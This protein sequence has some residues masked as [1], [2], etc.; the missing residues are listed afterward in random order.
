M[1]ICDRI[2]FIIQYYMQPHKENDYKIANL[3]LRLINAA[4]DT[5]IISTVAVLIMAAD[6][7]NKY[8]EIN[9]FNEGVHS[10]VILY[11]T[12]QFFYYIT[13]ESI[14]GKT[15]GKFISNTAIVNQDT[16]KRT[17]IINILGWTF[18]RFIPGY[19]IPVIFTK[20]KSGLHDI[21]GK[22]LV[23]EEKP[24]GIIV[25][26]LMF[27]IGLAIISLQTYLRGGY[28]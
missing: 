2:N 16:Y 11:F 21:I 22:T 12:I 26:I 13:L 5:S 7:T 18:I 19:S 25:N 8:V 28:M 23:I 14:F 20:N 3:F 9:Q 24:R 6:N 15:I 10:S 4:I 1:T 27:I 17:N